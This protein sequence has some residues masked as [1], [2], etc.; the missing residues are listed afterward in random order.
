MKFERSSVRCRSFLSQY[1]FQAGHHSDRGVWACVLADGLVVVRFFY[2]GKWAGQADP[3]VG[4]VTG[5]M[6]SAMNSDVAFDP[7]DVTERFF[8]GIKNLNEF[9][10]AEIRGVVDTLITPTPREIC[11]S[12]NYYRGVGNVETVLTLKSVKDF[13]AIAMLARALLELAIDIKLINA[14]PD[15]ISKILAFTDVEK[16]RLAKRI[17]AFKAANPSAEVDGTVYQ[18]FIT[19]NA[20]KIEAAR[21]AMWPGIRASDL[22]HWTSLNLKE[23][24][25]LLKGPWEELYAVYY[26]QLS[27]YVHS[28]ITGIVNLDNEAF[29]ALTAIAFTVIH[30]SYITLM[31]A[32]ID[33]FKISSANEQIRDK[34][35][36][37]KMLPFA[38]GSAEQM[39]LTRALLG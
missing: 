29:R 1:F 35:L 10:K 21:T 36:L 5:I 2:G 33:E 37:A 22:R 6:I 4:P 18:R 23:R 25:D 16:L 8:T 9:D 30:Q 26:P 15:S 34:M 20:T 11:F 12:G 13:Q 24:V 19:L 27:L 7:V 14:V 3:R 32:V 28:G 39:A 17:L 31:T 38:N